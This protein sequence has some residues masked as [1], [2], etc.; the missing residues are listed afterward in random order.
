MKSLAALAVL[1]VA[2]VAAGP[3]DARPKLRPAGVSYGGPPRSDGSR[4]AVWKPSPTTLRVLDDRDD[5]VSDVPVDAACGPISVGGGV[6]LLTCGDLYNVT[7]LLFDPAR[8]RYFQPVGSPS[9]V[10]IEDKVTPWAVGRHWIRFFRSGYHYSIS[11]F[12][13]WRT[14]KVAAQPEGERVN[15][16][17]DRPGLEAPLC[18]PLERPRF[19]YDT[20]VTDTWDDLEYARPWALVQSEEDYAVVPVQRCGGRRR[21]VARCEDFC[22]AVQLAGGRVFWLDGR[23]AWVHELASGRRA[24]WRTPPVPRPYS[25]SQVLA[26]TRK[27]LVFAV[28][29]D[30][31][32]PWR[33]FT[34]RPL[35]R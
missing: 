10:P 28:P 34:N 13:N 9:A 18:A 5:E 22:A 1:T 12:L 17:L 33:I 15:T 29:G 20:E 24:G 7:P 11:T 2:L 19:P 4:Y 26:P 3:A 30:Y 14:G 6:V 23:T 35:G 21:V 32:A 16:D 27:T 31:P 8:G 25:S